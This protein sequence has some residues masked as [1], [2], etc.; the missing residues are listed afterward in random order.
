MHY[1]IR[2][3]IPR[4]SKFIPLL[5]S[6]YHDSRIGGHSGVLK[7]LK[8]IQQAFYWADMR[9]TV[10]QYVAQCTVCQ[11]HKYSTLSPAGLLQPLPIPTQ[12][13]SDISL[14][15]VEDLPSSTGVNVILVVVD[16]L[17]K[18]GHFIGLHHPLTAVDVASKFV[19]EIVRLHG[20][21]ASII[22]DRD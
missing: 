14:D 12:I 20:F 11:T 5:L 17:S 15:F 19:S 16:R 22:S 13:W 7:T 2:L 1:K 9:R 8:R 10:Q 21:P 18:Y 3:L 6:E 4:T